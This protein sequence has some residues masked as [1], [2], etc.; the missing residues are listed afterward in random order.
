MAGL[1]MLVGAAAGVVG[2]IVAAHRAAQSAADLTALAGAA[3]LADHAGRDPCA[4]AGEVAV[5][6]GATL[7]S[8]TVEGSDV[9]VEVTVGGPRWL[10]QDQDLS[11]QARAGPVG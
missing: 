4:A 10:G 11:A 9:V 3:T 1:L 6:N 2:A 5:A 8:C 7:A